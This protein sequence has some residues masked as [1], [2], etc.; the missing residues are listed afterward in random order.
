MEWL[1]RSLSRIPGVVAVA[2]G[3]SRA[4]GTDRPD[5]DWDFGLYYRGSIDPQ[6]I[7]NLGYEGTVV[8]PGA[9]AYPM[10]G[11]AWLTVEGQKVDLLYRDLDD[12]ER[13]VERSARGD[14]ELYRMPGFVCGFPSYALVAELSLARVLSGR[15]PRPEFPDALR[16]P[17]AE[18][19][20]WERD[21]A[22]HHARVHAELAQTAACLGTLSFA[23]IAEGQARL[24]ER[25]EW[26]VNEKHL[27]RRTGL[28][29]LEEE[30]M[31]RLRAAEE[32]TE[33]ASVASASLVQ[34]PDDRDR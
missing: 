25:G 28:A 16:R 12:V 17:A 19:W 5:S 30:L 34:P 26:V 6:D 4:Q 24:A 18:R 31:L 32:L 3:G 15:L 22:I 8:P 11:G 21:F 23:L 9:W 7:R 13:W 10:N 33:V 20:R 29:S 2:L 27:I 14:W 1:A